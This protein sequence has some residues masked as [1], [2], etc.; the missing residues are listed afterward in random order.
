M[1]LFHSRHQRQARTLARRTFLAAVGL[2]IAA[3]LASK[4]ARLAV[5]AEGARPKRLFIYVLPHGLPVEHWD[6]GPEFNLKKSGQGVLSVFEPFKS[7]LQ[8]MQGI[9]NTVSDNHAA[10]SSVLTGKEGSDSIDYLVA[11]ALGT[12]AHVLGVQAYRQGSAGPDH[13]SHITHH[14]GWVTPVLNPADALDDLFAGLGSNTPTPDV[15]DESQFRKEALG[16][17]VREVEA[18]QGKLTHLTTEKNKLQIHLDSLRSVL[19]TLEGG[20]GQITSCTER[21]ALP[22]ASAMAGKNVWDMANF[23]GLIDGHLEAVAQSFVCGSAR[24]ATLQLMFANCELMMNFPGGPGFA[25]AHHGALSHSMTVSG[26]SPTRAEF[27]LTQQWFYKKLADKLLTV[28]EQPD[29]SDPSHTV[30]DNTTVLICTEIS[31]GA[32]HNSAEKEIWLDG[33]G[34]PTSLPWFILGGGGGY[35]KPGQSV[36][37][38]KADHR[39][40]LKTVAA[41]MDVNVTSIGGYDAKELAELKA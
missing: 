32:L 37:F 1:H 12:K 13:D 3:P 6:V 24:V 18:M 10:I 19:A 38:T 20:G 27:A 31:D 35:F 29:P 17:T 33:R 40:V 28:L 23:S 41:A 14:G 15:V 9:S 26:T 30:L 22:T 5:A 16:L 11:N 7:K 39:D 2:G 25:F 8:V 4:M 21:P 36:D 34:I